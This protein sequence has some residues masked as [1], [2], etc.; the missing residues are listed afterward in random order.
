MQ[1]LLRRP[2]DRIRGYAEQRGID[3][4]QLADMVDDRYTIQPSNRVGAA[5]HD[6]GQRQ[7]RI[8]QQR[9]GTFAPQI[10]QADD[11]NLL[12]FHETHGPDWSD[13]AREG[14]L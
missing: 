6:S 5:P 12:F 3:F 11:R 13:C 9:F 2:E 7:G 1:K 8:G 4:S 14:G 10:S